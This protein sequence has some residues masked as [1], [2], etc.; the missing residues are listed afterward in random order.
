M[1]P[2]LEQAT[3]FTAVNASCERRRSRRPLECLRFGCGVIGTFSFIHTSD[4]LRAPVCLI[5]N[6]KRGDYIG[7]RRKRQAKIDLQNYKLN[8]KDIVKSL[9][10]LA[11]G[12]QAEIHFV[13]PSSMFLLQCDKD[14]IRQA[15]Y[16]LVSNSLKFVPYGAGYVNIVALQENGEMKI[17]VQDNGKG[18]PAELHQLI[19]DKFFQA[20]NQTLKKPEG[21]GLGLAICK[22]IVE[23]H[24]GNIWVESP[25]EGG[26]KFIVTLP[27]DM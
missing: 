1:A 8:L 17:W 10:P 15:I 19:F 21:S 7:R 20:H 9:S 26:A 23:M 22:R 4:G 27:Y 24:N 16:N 6:F 25:P 18:I 3:V 13:S 11:I 14:L 2:Q 5:T 12:K